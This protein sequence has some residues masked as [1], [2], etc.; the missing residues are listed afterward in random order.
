MI[1]VCKLIVMLIF[2]FTR[3]WTTNF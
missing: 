2:F 1:N 3:T